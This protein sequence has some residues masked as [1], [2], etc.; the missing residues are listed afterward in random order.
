MGREHF[1]GSPAA[2]PPVGM[3]TSTSTTSGVF[4]HLNRG[5]HAW[6]RCPPRST[7]ACRA[8]RARPRERVGGHPRGTHVMAP[9]VVAASVVRGRD[10]S[11]SVPSPG[12]DR[13]SPRSTRP[14]QGGRRWSPRYPGDRRRLRLGSKPWPRSHTKIDTRCG[15]TSRYVE[16]RRRF[17]MT[18]RIHHRPAAARSNGCIPVGRTVG[19]THDFYR[20]HRAR[21]PL[22]RRAPRA[23]FPAIRSSSTD[24]CRHRSS[25]QLRN[26]RFS[27]Q[28]S[29]A[30]PPRIVGVA[31][32]PA[33]AFAARNRASAVADL[34]RRFVGVDALTS[35]RHRV[36]W[37]KSQTPGP[38]DQARSRRRPRLRRPTPASTARATSRCSRRTPRGRRRCTRFR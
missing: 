18:H 1:R 9:H 28:V 29:A 20:A 35:L 4:N 5:I 23:P 14:C 33:R 15:S 6:R 25:N 19:D 17:R 7:W 3:R 16:T 27:M 30:R 31:A 13:T 37:N 8:W 12:V 36:G 2:P 21:S 38:D 26:S 10:I 24:C 32:A 34:R 22:L 11:T